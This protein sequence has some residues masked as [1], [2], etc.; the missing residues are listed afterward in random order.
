MGQANCCCLICE[1]EENQ[2]LA[3]NTPKKPKKALPL[4][5]FSK[6]SSY[7]KKSK[8]HSG[9]QEPPS[10]EKGFGGSI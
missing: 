5:S 2:V 8:S 7:Q 6:T 10:K 1:I 9:S 3:K 4:I